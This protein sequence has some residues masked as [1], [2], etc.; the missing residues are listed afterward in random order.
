MKKIDLYEIAIKVLGLYLIT[1]VIGQF[2]SILTFIPAY[3]QQGSPLENSGGLDQASF[4]LTVCFGFML[5]V[6]FTWILLFRTK[7]VTRLIC[8][9]TDEMES[10]ELFAERKTVYE[11]CLVLLG[12]VTIVYTL[13]D[14]IVKLKS[15]VMLAKNGFSVNSYD[16]TFLITSTIKVVM[17]ILAIK[18]SVQISSY[19]A[20]RKKIS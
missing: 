5:L 20:K 12:L 4:F 19:L 17:G 9:Q 14:F 7:Q 15:Y 16:K 2:Q 6:I 10:V 11:I 3:L 13:P 1:V 18:Y 8:K